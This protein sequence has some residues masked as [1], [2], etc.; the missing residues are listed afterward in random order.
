MKY[1][2]GPLIKSA[3]MEDDEVILRFDVGTLRLRD[4]GQSCCETR[5]MSTDDDLQSLVGQRFV[6]WTV[7]DVPDLENDDYNVHEIAFLELQTDQGFVT[8]ANHNEHNGYYGGFSIQAEWQDPNGEWEEL[9]GIY[10]KM[11]DT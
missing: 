6:C 8:I 5:Y 10:G 1:V 11:I 3:T 2:K 7:K 9:S 4:C